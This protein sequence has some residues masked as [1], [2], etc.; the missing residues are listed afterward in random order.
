MGSETWVVLALM[1][2]CGPKPS[3]F[4]KVAP[5]THMPAI[6]PSFPQT[7][8]DSDISPN[9]SPQEKK[10]GNFAACSKHHRTPLSLLEAQGQIYT[11]IPHDTGSARSMST[12]KRSVTST[13]DLVFCSACKNWDPHWKKSSRCHSV[14]LFKQN[15]ISYSQL[16]TVSM[17]EVISQ[18]K[19]NIWYSL[20][21][22][23][24]GNNVKYCLFLLQSK[25]QKAVWFRKV[26]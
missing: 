14:N 13:S 17:H 20:Q 11:D 18:H 22:E 15:P 12:S 7:L 26:Q 16:H 5:K 4:S 21:R 3:W 25:I 23:V 2:T 8:L 10:T 24:Y 9:Q 6:I 19:K 1:K